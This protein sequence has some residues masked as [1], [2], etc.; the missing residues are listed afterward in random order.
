MGDEGAMSS[1]TEER[2]LSLCTAPY[3]SED[4]AGWSEKDFER[5]ARRVSRSVRNLEEESR[6]IGSPHHIVVD[7][8]SSWLEMPGP[9]SPRLLADCLE[10]KGF[11]AGLTHYGNPSI[12]TDAP[13]DLVAE[14][15]L[16]LQPPM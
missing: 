6:V 10:E 12:R 8:L 2:A 16:S 13:W 9:P 3:D 14:V 1:M 5:E 7:D 4:V 11:K 15:A